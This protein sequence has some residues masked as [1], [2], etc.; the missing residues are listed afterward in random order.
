MT[1]RGF[2]RYSWA[3]LAYNILVIVWGAYVRASG[4]GA[5]CG[6][7]WP[8]CNGVV[9]PQ[10][11]QAATLIEFAHRLMSGVSLVLAVL[12]VYKASRVFEAGHLARKGAWFALLFTLCEAL[13]GAGLVLLGL[14]ADNASFARALALALHLFNTFLL[15]AALALTSWWAAGGGAVRLRGQGVV[16]GAVGVALGA[17]LLLGMSGSI[18][19]LGDTLFPSLSLLEGM[20]QDFDATA[21]VLIRLRLLHPLIA[22]GAG[23][24]LFVLSALLRQRRPSRSVTL[25]SRAL[26]TLLL[27]Q[28]IVGGL[29]VLLLAPI[30]SQLAHLLMADA[31][32][33]SLVLL[34][35]AALAQPAEQRA[36]AKAPAQHPQ[37]TTQTPSLGG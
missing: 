24:H 36:H 26:V 31:L 10:S 11:P 5:G 27:L 25:L 34:A 9:L 30:W 12:L 19:A 14:V 33:V 17:V 37:A 16:G 4:S 1:Q 29:V 2:V 28:M 20:R 8:L 6:S 35:A 7:H 23:V 18:A 15:L 3:V 22:V 13:I 21:H 32:W